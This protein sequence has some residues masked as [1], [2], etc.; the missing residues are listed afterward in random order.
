MPTTPVLA[1]PYPAASDTADVP[2]DIQALATKLD[3]YT[4]LRPPLVTS[5]PGS[6]VDG[7]ECYFQADATKGVVWAL[8]YRTAASGSYKWEVTGGP[9]LAA[10]TVSAAQTAST[11]YVAI[12][13][14][15]VTVPLAGDYIVEVSIYGYGSPN[16]GAIGLASPKIGAAAADDNNAA[17]FTASAAAGASQFTVSVKRLLTIAAA[18]TAVAVNYKVAAAGGA[19]NFPARVLSVAPVRVG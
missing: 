11:T 3:G 10:Q 8:R 14:P 6:P 12:D 13:G 1:L 15:G 19:V 18:A 2:R 9:P 16:P 5:L 7:Q 17:I 4:S